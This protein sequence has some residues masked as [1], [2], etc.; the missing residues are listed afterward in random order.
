MNSRLFADRTNHVIDFRDGDRDLTTRFALFVGGSMDL[1]AG[2]E[3]AFSALEHRLAGA[4]LLADGL[5]DLLD[6][7][8][9]RLGRFRDALRTARLFGGGPCDLTDPFTGVPAGLLN[10]DQCRARIPRAFDA[11]GDGFDPGLHR[12]H[13]TG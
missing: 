10:R 12:P 13:C 11:L 8:R 1:L 2:F 7:G 4:S 5:A 3:G 9:G 6:L